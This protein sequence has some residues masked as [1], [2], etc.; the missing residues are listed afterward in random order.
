MALLAKTR[1]TIEKIGRSIPIPFSETSD[2][3]PDNVSDRYKN[4]PSIIGTALR[5]DLKNHLIEIEE[6]Y[7]PIVLKLSGKIKPWDL[8]NLNIARINQAQDDIKL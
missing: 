4:N 6:V 7:M 5:T 1:N 3:S 2:V 8:F